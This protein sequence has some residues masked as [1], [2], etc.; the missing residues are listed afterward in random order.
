VEAQG[1]GRRP[2]YHPLAGCHPG[3]S[4]AADESKDLG[5]V[6]ES[7]KQLENPA[8]ILMSRL[9]KSAHS[10][11]KILRRHASLPQN[12][13]RSIQRKSCFINNLIQK[14]LPW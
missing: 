5:F 3:E 2:R 8:S 12:Q 7:E 9:P 13:G 4:A 14:T 11:V 10:V 6:V 1:F